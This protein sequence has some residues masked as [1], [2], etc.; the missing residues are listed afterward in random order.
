MTPRVGGTRKPL[1]LV[2]VYVLLIVKLRPL[3]N[4]QTTCMLPD[5]LLGEFTTASESR[6]GETNDRATW[7]IDSTSKTYILIYESHIEITPWEQSI[8]GHTQCQNI[9]SV[10]EQLYL[11][12]V[13][14]GA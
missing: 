3:A 1:R 12:V 2:R 6:I 8:H 13:Y 10:L 4:S 14:Y 5:S 7:D 9:T 11:I